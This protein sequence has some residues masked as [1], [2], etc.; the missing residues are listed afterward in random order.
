[1]NK[2]KEKMLLSIFNLKCFFF[3]SQYAALAAGA[4]NNQAS[5]SV[6]GLDGN[7]QSA[8]NKN[9]SIQII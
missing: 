1:M 7:H 4:Y 3:V 9:I 8:G 5:N 2:V 6:N